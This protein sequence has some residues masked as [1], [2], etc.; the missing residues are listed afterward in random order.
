MQ[1][2]A[3]AGLG[4]LAA[5]RHPMPVFRQRSISGPKVR[6]RRTMVNHTATC[7][8][9][10]TTAN[11]RPR[12]G[13]MPEEVVMALMKKEVTNPG[14]PLEAV[15]GSP[16]TILGPEAVFD[17]TLTFKG[18]VRIDGQFSGKILTEDVVTIG[19][20]AEVN[21]EVQV[22]A[23]KL[24]GTLKGNVIAKRSVELHPPARLYGDIATPSLV[25]H[26]GVIFEGNCRMENLDQAKPAVLKDNKPALSEVKEDKPETKEEKKDDS[27]KGN[28]K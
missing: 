26:S 22:G 19:K 21:A 5:S 28:K 18:Q 10:P 23:L 2:R 27:N 13:G 3:T 17:G 25:I 20:D 8:S 24:L 7:S 16:H 1:Q 11:E 12:W 14:M 6:P 9:P 4:P 15:G